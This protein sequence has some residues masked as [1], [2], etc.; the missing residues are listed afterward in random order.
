MY[1]MR[2]HENKEARMRLQNCYGQQENHKVSAEDNLSQVIGKETEMFW[3][4]KYL[5]P[6]IGQLYT[7]EIPTRSNHKEN[8]K[9]INGTI[10]NQ[11]NIFLG[12]KLKSS[13]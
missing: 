13:R 11:P 3:G 6:H 10:S 12:T 4:P 1:E 7:L 8:G 5:K 2:P 9:S